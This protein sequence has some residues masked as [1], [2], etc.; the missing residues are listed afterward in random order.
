MAKTEGGGRGL[1]WSEDACRGNACR[2][3]CRYGVYIYIY[4][5]VCR[6]GDDKSPYLL[7]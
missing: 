7:C 5:C 4:I 6:H 2:Q 1:V 3:T